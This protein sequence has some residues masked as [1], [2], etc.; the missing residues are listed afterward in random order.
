MPRTRW[1]RARLFLLSCC[2][3][4]RA[5]WFARTTVPTFPFA[6]ASIPIADV[7]T[8]ALTAML[9]PATT[10]LTADGGYRRGKVVPLK[11]NVD[12]ALRNVYSTGYERTCGDWAEG[13]ARRGRR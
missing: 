11:E 5:R 6:T 13:L 3:T 7:N 12:A 8:V 4:R 10:I 1:L 9:A 2:L